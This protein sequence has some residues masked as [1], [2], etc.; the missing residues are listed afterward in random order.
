V[1]LQV[2]TPGEDWASVQLEEPKLPLELLLKETLPVGV[3]AVPLV[4]SLTVAV[5]VVAVLT[6]RVEGEQLTEVP[7]ERFVP[8]TTKVPELALCFADMP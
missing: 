8:L 4:V 6:V 1:T 2:A 3:P 7:V 5:H